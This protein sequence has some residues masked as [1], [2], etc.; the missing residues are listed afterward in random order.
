MKVDECDVGYRQ[1][2]QLVEA[3]AAVACQG[4]C[5]KA[6]EVRGGVAADDDAMRTD[7]QSYT[8]RHDA[9][10]VI[11][12]RRSSDGLSFMSR[13]EAVTAELRDIVS[14]MGDL[15]WPILAVDAKYETIIAGQMAEMC[16]LEGRLQ[17]RQVATGNR[18]VQKPM[19]VNQLKARPQPVPVK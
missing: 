17:E 7:A 9:A 1:H 13:A 5:R 12:L 8:S 18:E 2:G 14:K 11:P 10:R 15:G 4:W 3:E 19:V 16:R 6:A